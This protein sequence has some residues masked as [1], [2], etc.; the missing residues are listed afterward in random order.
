MIKHNNMA[1]PSL[2]RNGIDWSSSERNDHVVIYLQGEFIIKY[3]RKVK[4][5]IKG[6]RVI[7]F[8]SRVLVQNLEFLKLQTH[9]FRFVHELK[10]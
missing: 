1:F 9:P 2:E 7:G 4:F 10:T 6:D 3:R 5:L 8:D